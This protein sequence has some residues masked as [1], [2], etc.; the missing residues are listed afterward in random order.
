MSMNSIFQDLFMMIILC[1]NVYLGLKIINLVH[2]V[3]IMKTKNIQLNLNGIMIILII[4]SFVK[5]LR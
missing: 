2:F 1:L 5:Q 3:L 4:L